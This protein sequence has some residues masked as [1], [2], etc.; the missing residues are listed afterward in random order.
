MEMTTGY[1]DCNDIRMFYR[2]MGTGPPLLLLHGGWATGEMNWYRHY[3]ALC[4]HFRVISP[5]NRGHGRTN[6]PSGCEFD[7]FAT[8]ANDTATF[9]DKLDLPEP[10][11]IMGHST[12]GWIALHLSVHHCH[13]RHVKKQILLGMH[14]NIAVSR[15]FRLGMQ[16][17]FGT[18]DYRRPPEKWAFVRRHPFTAAY[19]WW[20]HKHVNW[21][22]LVQLAWPMW[23]KPLEITDE[24]YKAIDCPTL[25]LYGELEEYGCEHDYQQLH[26][27]ICGS[28]LKWVEGSGHLFVEEKPEEFRKALWPFLFPDGAP[29]T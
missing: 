5:D 23:V 26:E 12:G 8:L 11:I 20:V 29:D 22:R 15:Q 10:P 2:D 3:E 28:E 16:E 9:L 7:S 13:R 14:G 1:I 19:L 25:V 24:Q 21:H 18:P 6:H 17:H 4:K 27:K